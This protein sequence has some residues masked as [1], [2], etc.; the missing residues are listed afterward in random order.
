MAV[1]QL[2]TRVRIHST[3]IKSFDL[4]GGMVHEA[5]RKWGQ[6]VK[7]LA[8]ITCPIDTGELRER[9]YSFVRQAPL[10]PECL[11]G[12]TAPHALWVHEGT[13]VEDIGYIGP[14]GTF[15]KP[16]SS[17]R[18]IQIGFTK[19]GGIKSY[20]PRMALR[21]GIFRVN[22]AGQEPQRWLANALAAVVH[23]NRIGS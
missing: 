14:Y 6:E 10:G 9:H 12:A 11:V 17:T 23:I 7:E 20:A 15:H 22:V 4:P 18:P 1:I 3:V 5:V 13:R 2:R 8:Q 21:T 16:I 19:R